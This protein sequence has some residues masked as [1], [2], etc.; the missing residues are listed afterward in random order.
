MTLTYKLLGRAASAA[1]LDGDY[2]LALLIT[3]LRSVVCPD[4]DR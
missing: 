2:R 4:R 3:A 1:R